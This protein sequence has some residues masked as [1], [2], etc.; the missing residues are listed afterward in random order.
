MANYELIKSAKTVKEYDVHLCQ[1]CG[2][3]VSGRR[4]F[5]DEHATDLNKQIYE[6]F[7]DLP[8]R[9]RGGKMYDIITSYLGT[10]LGILKDRRIILKSVTSAGKS[11]MMDMIAYI[12]LTHFPNSE[13]VIGSVSDSVSKEHIMRL[14]TW[15]SN[16]LFSK[17]ISGS[18]DATASKTEIHLAHL[19][20]RVISIPQAE[21]TR[22]GWHPSLLLIDEIGRM[23]PDSYWGCYSDD[24]EVLTED[25]WVELK[26]I[27]ENKL[28]VPIATLNR[29]KDVVEYHKPTHFFTYPYKGKM[30]HQYAQGIIDLLVTPNHQCYVKSNYKNSKWRFSKAEDLPKHYMIDKHFPWE[31]ERKEFFVLPGVPWGQTNKICDPKKFLM[32]DWLAFFGIWLAEGSSFTSKRKTR[33]EIRYMVQ[34]AQE[35]DENREQIK[36]ICEKLGYVV[37]D[38]GHELRIH[39]K[40]LC[41]YLKQFGHSHDKYIPNEFKNLSRRQLNILL[42]WMIL[43]DGHKYSKTNYAYCTSSRQLADD[44][45]E[46]GLKVGW[47]LSQTRF[48]ERN[49][50]CYVNMRKSRFTPKLNGGKDQREWIDYDGYVYDIEIPNHLFYV[51]RNKKCMWNSNS[52]YQMGKL[53][54]IEVL[55]STPF[56]DSIVM[57]DVWN[58]EGIKRVSLTPE[59]CWWID[60]RIFTQAKKDLPPNLYSQLYEA[61]FRTITN[62][63]IPD[64]IFL[65]ALVRGSHLPQSQN[66]LMGVDFGQ[67]IDP[68]AVVIID[69]ETGDV[70]FTTHFDDPWKIQFAKIRQIYKE[71]HPIKIMADKSSIG[72]VII[73]ELSDLPIEGVSMHND[74][75]KKRVIDRVT[76]AFINHKV[77]IVADEFP[78]LVSQ[79][80]SYVYLDQDRKKMGPS[81]RGHDDFVDA[82]GLA[83]MAFDVSSITQTLS[84]ENIWTFT[85]IAGSA[86]SPWK[87]GG[88]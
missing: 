20:S 70:K 38:T 72:S 21:K 19:N 39:N 36:K 1:Y 86:A 64:D 5:C 17:Y 58:S 22:T 78:M 15:I 83:L 73:D 50:C 37:Q 13:T 63:V 68:T 61:K 45:Y 57:Q 84:T 62:R 34:I 40:Q 24:T 18:R 71:W 4:L 51:R 32:D 8:V 69:M 29:E 49:D 77:N 23:K 48:Y 42:E 88:F 31:G 60:K 9:P 74:I 87:I 6:F 75:L 28:A 11:Y 56:S 46:I 35:N 81:G 85:R 41:F 76:M 2:K 55:A 43:G 79:L 7:V 65:E 66:L 12:E 52:F 26:A 47:N 10:R 54:A 30:F 80:S 16:S 3:E 27:C 25:G 53:R 44:V 14:R 59:D 33:K 67:K 82:L